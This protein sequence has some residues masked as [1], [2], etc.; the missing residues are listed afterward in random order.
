MRK[1]II[2]LLGSGFFILLIIIILSQGFWIDYKVYLSTDIKNQA[3]LFESVV[4]G[5]CEGIVTF[6]ALYITIKHEDK[7]ERIRWQN[8][9]NKVKSNY[10]LSVRPF[11]NIDFKSLSINRSD[12]HE[13][14]G[15][16]IKIG[17]GEYYRYATFYLANRGNGDCKKILLENRECSVK[18]LEVNEK[19]ELV[20]YFEGIEGGDYICDFILTFSYQDIFGNKYT[21]EFLCVFCGSKQEIKINIKEALFKEEEE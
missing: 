10:I 12:K 3:K 14:N 13:S 4:N 15:N 2:I 5:I 18:Q 9:K 16:T 11:L 6:T 20:I 21:Q 1:R 7:K 8:E 17:D 19:K